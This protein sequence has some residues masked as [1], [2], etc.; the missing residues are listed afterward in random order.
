MNEHGEVEKTTKL[1]KCNKCGLLRLAEDPTCGC[2]DEIQED[3]TSM[4]EKLKELEKSIE[5]E[6]CGEE[7]GQNQT[8]IGDETYSYCKG[9]NWITH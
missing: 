2:V 6:K 9:C 7:I 1:R 5:C 3:T 4:E 8:L